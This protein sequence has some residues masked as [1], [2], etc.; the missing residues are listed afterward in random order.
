[1]RVNSITGLRGGKQG[2]Q[3]A[4]KLEGER[5]GME[6]KKR[7]EWTCAKFVGSLYLFTLKVG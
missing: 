1:M 7:M 3:Q 4:G 5:G 2:R 6:R